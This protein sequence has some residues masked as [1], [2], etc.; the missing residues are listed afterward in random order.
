MNDESGWL[1]RR[2]PT[3]VAGLDDIFSGGLLAGRSYL[4]LGASG[5]GKTVLAS[6]IACHR[7]AHGGRVVF[8]SLLIEDHARLLENLRTFTFFDPRCVP[9]GIYLVAGYGFL[10]GGLGE[11]RK[12]LQELLHARQADLLVIDSINTI[13]SHARSTNEYREFLHQLQAMLGLFDCTGIFLSHHDDG[14][15]STGEHAV[16]DGLVQLEQGMAGMRP[17]RHLRILKLRGSGHL[18]GQHAFTIASDGITC[19]PRLEARADLDDATAEAPRTVLPVGVAGLDEMLGGGVLSASS[20]I[21]LGSSGVGKT[22][23]GLHFL[24]EGACRDE[25]GLY[26]GFY[27]RTA[28][29]EAQADTLGI[30]LRRRRA[31]GLVTTLWQPPLEATL[32]ALAQR[33]LQ[34]VARMRPARLVVDGLDGF[35]NAAVTPDR[36]PRVVAAISHELRE[37]G[38]TTL[39][40]M[41]RREHQSPTITLPIRGISAIV[42]NVFYL[43]QAEVRSELQRFVSIFKVRE[44]D[45]DPRLRRFTIS[46]RGLA[47]AGPVDGVEGLLS[48]HTHTLQREE[49]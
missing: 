39:F 29:L 5:T 21:V 6:Q 28:R 40:T 48:G 30:P 41:E 42:D 45:F 27:E 37:R 25:R 33:L 19:Y 11:L 43:H 8:V 15:T 24:A 1:P 34:A 35:A 44:R 17:L 12:M 36:L 47:V 26:F 20:T 23:L 16:L 13:R 49:E 14:D 3:G 9:D 4:V 2:L 38:I 10:Q 46:G 18:E 22:T 7:V 32:D 31:E